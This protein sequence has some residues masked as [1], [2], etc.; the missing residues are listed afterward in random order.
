MFLPGST[1]Q[2]EQSTLLPSMHSSH[3]VKVPISIIF[4]GHWWR[5]VCGHVELSLG[6]CGLIMDATE[7]IELPMF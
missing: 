2:L 5:G 6:S 7:C 3:S 1:K 4:N